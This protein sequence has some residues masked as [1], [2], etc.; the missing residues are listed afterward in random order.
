[1]KEAEL[2]ELLTKCEGETIECKPDILSRKEIAEYAVGIGNAGGGWL[3][4]GV[5]DRL[6]RQ[7][8]PLKIS[9]ENE[10]AKIRESVADS[11]QIRITIEIVN[12]Q[13]GPV[14]VTQI[15]ARPRGMPYH[16]RD[17]KYLI[18]L[19]E[20]LRGMTLAEIDDIR[21]EAGMEL[22][23]QL[24]SDKAAE[25]ISPAGM[26]ELRRMMGEAGASPDLVKLSDM[27]LLRSLGVLS[28]DESLLIAGV[29]LV[30]KPEA[31]RRYLPHAQWQFRRMKSDED[32]VAAGN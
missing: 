22:T 28:S 21:R 2:R 17:G 23:A 20:E 9:S 7:V 15:P 29:L 8:L 1:M 32:V 13:N 14:L 3:I 12:T 16:T 24:I 18:R 10:L 25:L 26:E 19:G 4:M 31:I 6:P 11:A 5:S 30:G 27:D